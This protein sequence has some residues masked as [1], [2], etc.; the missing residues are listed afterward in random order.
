MDH[1]RRG[2]V[3]PEQH[4]A[5]AAQIHVLANR[6]FRYLWLSSLFANFGTLILLVAAAWSMV[7]LD[8]RPTM[9]ALVQS[10]T[11]APILVFG[12]LAG[13]L[14]D[15][16]DR[17]RVAL[18]AIAASFGGAAAL[19]MLS[20]G[21]AL[22][23][24]ILLL[25]CFVVGTGNA[26]FSPAW[27]TSVAEQVT[28]A[29]LPQAIMLNSV[30]YNLARSAGPG[31]GG[32]LVSFAGPIA[33]F[34]FTSL[35]FLPISICFLLWKRTPSGPGLPREPLHHALGAGV[36][37]GFHNAA[38]RPA[39]WRALLVGLTGC[40]LIALAPLVARD[41]IGGGSQVFGLLLA[42]LGVGAISGA[43]GQGRLRARFGTEGS[44]RLLSILGGL[45]C[46]LVA[47]NAVLPLTCLGFALAG[48]GYAGQTALINIFIQTNSPRWVAARTLALFQSVLAGGMAVGSWLWGELAG[49]AGMTAAIEAATLAFA[50]AALAGILY[51]IRPAALAPAGA[52]DLTPARHIA[53]DRLDLAAGP[54]VI[55]ITYRIPRGARGR[56]LELMEEVRA[57]RLR[58]GARDWS[59]RH[60]LEADVLWVQRFMCRDW[61]EFLHL[62]ERSSPAERALHAEVASLVEPGTEP[63]VQFFEMDR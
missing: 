51:P 37:Y 24:W 21:D 42:S 35:A 59:L 55:E 4:G 31:I 40:A 33:G 52:E 2:S 5:D 63:A 39:I 56:F 16:Y 46:G 61:R 62:R 23:P 17:R 41:M 45:G 32:L 1:A 50:L 29:E 34:L 60:S 36:R 18:A 15:L 19:V 44:T 25:C 20:F 30:S 7:H 58:N 14:A 3:M 11:L 54:I 6:R 47:L 13:T 12:L 26:A 57:S 49:A 48:A 38:L 43:M 27:Q 9:V 53:A 8:G 22:S 10:A 28:T